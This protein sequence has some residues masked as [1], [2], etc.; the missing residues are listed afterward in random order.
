[1]DNFDSSISEELIQ[2][3]LVDL[4]STSG[5]TRDALLVQL[6]A[7]DFTTARNGGFVSAARSVWGDNGESDIVAEWSSA[8]HERLRL[9]IEVKLTA[10]FMKRQGTRYQERAAAAVQ[11]ETGLRALCVLVAPSAYVAAANPEADRF[12][13]HVPLEFFI[14]KSSPSSRGV[15]LISAALARIAA[16]S[17]LGAKGL[18]PDLHRALHAECERRANGLSV[19]NKATDWVTLKGDP[20]PTGVNLNYR[21]RNGVAEIRVLS[22]YKGPRAMLERA[23]DA[24][25][26]AVKSGGEL[27][28]KHKALRVSGGA[29]SGAASKE[30]VE[31]IVR[32][33][34][35]LQDWW[36]RHSGPPQS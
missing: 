8:A 36:F 18:F 10:G 1:M 29:R 15:P 28:L 16:D 13:H 19:R 20:W 26:R 34:E 11:A 17:P 12:D 35:E 21:I 33:M 14:E 23:D 27:F 6:G 3:A 5:S 22:S 7:G 30:D 4:L 9:L 24:I 25:V 31:T 2:A 32:V